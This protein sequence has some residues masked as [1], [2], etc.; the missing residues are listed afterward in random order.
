[1]N[2][3][4]SEDERSNLHGRHRSAYLGYSGRPVGVAPAAIVWSTTSVGAHS[5]TDLVP[6]GGDVHVALSSP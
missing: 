2:A 3:N 4:P 5:G 1:M 6:L